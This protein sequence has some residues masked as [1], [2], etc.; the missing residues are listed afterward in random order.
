MT[1]TLLAELIFGPNEASRTR[2]FGQFLAE[3]LPKLLFFIKWSLVKVKNA[4]KGSSGAG[5][6]A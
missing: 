4:E 3:K 1:T 5:E 6:R 2:F